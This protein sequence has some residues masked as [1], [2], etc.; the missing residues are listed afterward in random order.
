MLL[1]CTTATIFYIHCIGHYCLHQ[2]FNHLPFYN[3]LSFLLGTCE[4]NVLYRSVLLTVVE[5]II[6]FY[7]IAHWCFLA[8]WPPFL[9]SLHRPLLTCTH[10]YNHLYFYYTTLL[11]VTRRRRAL[12]LKGSTNIK[13]SVGR[14][15]DNISLQMP[16]YKFCY[17]S[18]FCAFL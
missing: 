14:L 7:L 13:D 6:S 11:S 2:C 10:W 17:T 16:Y 9:F 8:L 5:S 3:H 18:L 15:D 1:T 4:P 12:E